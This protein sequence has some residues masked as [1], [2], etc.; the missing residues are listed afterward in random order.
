MIEKGGKKKALMP[1]ELGQGRGIP[2]LSF[3]KRVKVLMYVAERE[4]KAARRFFEKVIIC[5]IRVS[6]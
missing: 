6:H 5:L 2:Q 1:I 4:I 3:V